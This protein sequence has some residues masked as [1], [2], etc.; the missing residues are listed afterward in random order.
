MFEWI[1]IECIF[2][3]LVSWYFSYKLSCLEIKLEIQEE[4]NIKLFEMIMK[5]SELQ[6]KDI[7][8]LLKVGK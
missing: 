5:H 2:L 3:F 4:K 6:D 1:F 8:Y 7:D